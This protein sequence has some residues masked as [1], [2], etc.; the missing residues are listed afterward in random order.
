[1]FW[2]DL[3]AALL[4]IYCAYCGLNTLFSSI[5]MVI[6][7]RHQHQKYIFPLIAG[8]MLSIVIYCFCIPSVIVLTGSTSL[9][10]VQLAL[11]VAMSLVAGYI[12]HLFGIDKL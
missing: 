5:Q 6:D 9:S 4:G 12:F 8:I 11:F 7:L 10:N 2:I 3:L 1:M